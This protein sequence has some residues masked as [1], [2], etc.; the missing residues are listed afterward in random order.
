M[1]LAVISGLKPQ[2]GRLEKQLE[3][4]QIGLTQVAL[5]WPDT[6]KLRVGESIQE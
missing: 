3:N 4:K 2:W 6:S 5:H 1:C